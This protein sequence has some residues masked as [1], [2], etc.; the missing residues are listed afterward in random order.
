M[1]EIVQRVEEL[2]LQKGL[3]KKELAEAI[4]VSPTAV[5]AWGKSNVFPTLSNI[6]KICE[7]VGITFEQFFIG[8]G[9]IKTENDADRILKEWQTLS[10]EEKQLIFSLLDVFKSFT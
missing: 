10:N 1:N 4:G 9:E 5:Y 6:R 2:R 8:I 7:V 3:N